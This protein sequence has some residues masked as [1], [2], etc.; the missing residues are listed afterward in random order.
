MQNHR[1][2]VFCKKTIIGIFTKFTGK[3]SWSGHGWCFIVC[4]STFYLTT[5][6]VVKNLANIWDG[7]HCK[8]SRP[9]SAVSYCWNA[10]HLRYL[11]AVL[12]TSDSYSTE[13]QLNGYFPLPSWTVTLKRQVEVVSFNELSKSAYHCKTIVNKKLLFIFSGLITI[14][15]TG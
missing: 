14:N 4:F 7:E 11:N 13:N 8:N 3:N 12:V 6:G 9:F 5:R 1:S 2:F 15:T 10:L